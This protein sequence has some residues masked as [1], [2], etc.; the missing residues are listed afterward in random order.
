MRYRN[1]SNDRYTNSY[2][3][4]IWNGTSLDALFLFLFQ[5]LYKDKKLMHFDFEYSQM[6]LVNW[7]KEVYHLNHHLS[8]ANM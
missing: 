7:Q 3:K 2:E 5:L 4:P 1:L 6:E 8:N